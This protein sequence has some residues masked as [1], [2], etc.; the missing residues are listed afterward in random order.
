MPIILAVQ[1]LKQEDGKFKAS[2]DN[3]M[4]YWPV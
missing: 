3:I 2:L 4:S 1:K